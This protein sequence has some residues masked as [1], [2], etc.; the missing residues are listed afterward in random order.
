VVE[1]VTTTEAPTGRVDWHAVDADE[2]A[3]R[4]D[5]DLGSGLTEAVAR[6]RRHEVGPNRLAEAEPTPW[7]ATLLSQFR[8]PLIYILMAAGVITVALG[9]YLDA[10]VIAAVLVLNAGIGFAQER[11]AEA[12]VLAL[13]QLV[14][15]TARVVRD[16][17]Q[18]TIESADLVPG[19]VVLLESGGRVPAD[20][21]LVTTT[22]VEIDE[23]LLTGESVPVDKHPDVLPADTALA[24]RANMAFS[25]AI[26]ARG[27]ATGVVV[28]TGDGTELGRIAEQVRATAALRS[29]LQERMTR[30][31]HLIGAVIVVAAALTFGLGLLLGED[32][33][34][35][36]GTA[37]A[38]AVAAI[39]EG[40]PVVLTVAL[41]LGVRRMAHR[42]A[43]V[44]HLPAVE[45]LGSTTLIGSDKTGTL[46]ENRMS[47]E[48]LWVGGRRV[49]VGDDERAR[50][51]G[52]A[53]RRPPPGPDAPPEDL[54]LLTGVLANEA[55]LIVTDDGVET[56]GD[57]TE[58]A[59]LVAAARLGLDVEG[60]RSAWVEEAMIPFE[61]ERRYAASFRAHGDHH[62]VFVKGAPERVLEMCTHVV[63]EHG[64]R[65]D[66][67][68]DA[69]REVADEMAARG[70]RVL[71]TAHGT[72]PAAPAGPGRPERPTGLALVG[73]HG[74]LD[75]PRP[76][77]RDAI[78]GCRRAGQRVIMITGDH[79]A[80]ARAIALDLGL[81]DAD[82]APV[83][84]GAELEAMGDTELE[85]EVARVSVFARVSPEHKLR[86]VRAA[87][88]RGHVVAVTGDGVND[89]PALKAAD[90][91]V[92]MGRAGTD[93]AREASE[94]VLADDDF[95]SI[96]AAVEE[97]RV[98]F[99][100]VRKVTFFLVSTGFGT[101]I[102]IP[103]AMALG[104][105]LILLP[106]QLLWLNLVT[107]GLQDL[108]LAFEP[109][110]PDVLDHP[111]RGRDEPVITGPLWWRTVLSGSV[112]AAGTLVMFDWAQSAAAYDVEE[113]RSVALSTLVIFQ[114][115]HLGSC[116]S[117]L[118]SILRTPPLS[119][120]FLL[121]AQAGAL[122]VSVAALYLPPTQYVLRVE[123]IPLDAWPRIVAVALSV[124][125]VVEIDKAVRRHLER[126]RRVATA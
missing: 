32:V 124:L 62:A 108:A 26:V 29:P 82:D 119:N 63:D 51:P 94:I 74:L 71:A 72:L 106:A 1:L 100:N 75:P 35:M 97:G 25:G 40:L 105:P 27:R 126:K 120:R 68:A 22:S 117:E 58:T 73:L 28:A 98:T 4:L 123:P 101:F 37:A 83:L 67:D 112:M 64:E 19:D 20:V 54:A 15:P 14:S 5:T 2:V 114:A 110:E 116:R 125:V 113:A 12:S 77:V 8:S 36:V 90:I 122:V 9:E 96:Y 88:A 80:T 39:P 18:R 3:P 30:F 7:W 13:M 118:R 52:E 46:T 34:E 38:L 85:D 50:D 104:W 66:L 91:G 59:F 78:D 11:K 17:A 42:N 6:R 49:E 57:P 86:I 44:R 89:A 115:F 43:I 76:G 56:E 23:S 87:Q 55:S 81:V 10:A 79:A 24:D 47:V 31:A 111:P 95:V 69:V 70:L 92:A 102:I 93:V 84:T 16:G 121:L 53:D 48:E 33:R 99:D 109:G 41:A 103:I 60:C 61:S 65:V 107:K 45:T 21:R